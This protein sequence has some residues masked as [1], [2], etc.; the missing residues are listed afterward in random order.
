MGGLSLVW[1]E[2]F[3]GKGNRLY[4]PKQQGP[5]RVGKKEMERGCHLNFGDDGSP[6]G[7]GAGEGGERSGGHHWA[8]PGE[9]A[10]VTA[11]DVV[12][13]VPHD[14]GVHDEEASP[15]QPEGVLLCDERS[16]LKAQGDGYTAV[17]D[18]VKTR[19]DRILIY[20]KKNYNLEP[21]TVCLLIY[22]LICSSL[23]KNN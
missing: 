20:N 14:D 19:K 2:S 17:G 15:W 18:Q 8:G 7:A 3:G 21:D 22:I 1:H 11:R 13:L 5:Y 23:A 16:T 10:E 4:I 12:L 9:A 6:L